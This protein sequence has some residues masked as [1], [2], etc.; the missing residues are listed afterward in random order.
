MLEQAGAAIQIAL[1]QT[2]KYL[3]FLLGSP[4]L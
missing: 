3:Q 4:N 2:A 1:A